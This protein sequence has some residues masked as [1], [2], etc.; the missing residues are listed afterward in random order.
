M[1]EQDVQSTDAPAVAAPEPAAAAAPQAAIPAIPA[2]APT[3]DAT[4]DAVTPPENSTPELPEW[5]MKDKYKSIEDQAKAQ[6]EMRKLIG[7]VWGPPKDDYKMDGIQGIN[8]N[9]PVL[10]HLKPEL[11]EMGL[12]Q[13]GFERL[14]TKYQAAQVAAVTKLEADLKQTLTQKDATAI[15]D[16]DGW[17]ND[18]FS[19]E[20]AETMRSWIVNEKDFHLLSTLK[21][22]IPNKT[23]VPSTMSSNAVQFES[24]SEVEQDKIKYRKEIKAG[25]RVQDGNYETQLHNR[26]RDAKLREMRGKR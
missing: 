14:I 15:K 4:A 25:L 19:P 23:N 17:L 21:A 20:D 26:F 9:D 6:Y 5:F 24:A 12:S 3:P 16:V 13:E 1:S 7:P 2:T 18:S 11:K 8:P 22:M 10:A